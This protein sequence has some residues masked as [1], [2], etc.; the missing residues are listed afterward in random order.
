MVGGNKE[1][2]GDGDA[3]AICPLNC[4]T[5]TITEKV[6]HTFL[7]LEIKPMSVTRSKSQTS[8]HHKHN[9]APV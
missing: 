3:V 2:Q 9:T 1:G 7:K 8:E 5:A 6:L 4:R